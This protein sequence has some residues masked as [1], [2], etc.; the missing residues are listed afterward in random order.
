MSKFSFKNKN[1]LITG[2]SGGLGS[3]MA[4]FLADW[5]ARLVLTYRSERVEKFDRIFMGGLLG[6]SGGNRL[7]FLEKAREAMPEPPAGCNVCHYLYDM[8]RTLRQQDEGIFA[9]AR[10][11]IIMLTLAL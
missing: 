6:S 5:K 7:K 10:G 2:A 3:A 9:R 4:K 11:L 8:N 1:V